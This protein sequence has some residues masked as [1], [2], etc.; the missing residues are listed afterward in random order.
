MQ[1][2]VYTGYGG[3]DPAIRFHSPG[4][5]EPSGR[6]AMSTHPFGGL[7]NYHSTSFPA[8]DDF[9][10]IDEERLRI[11]IITVIVDP[12]LRY[13]AMRNWYKPISATSIASRLLPTNEWRTHEFQLDSDG[14]SWTYGD[15]L[16]T[17]RR[18]QQEDRP[19]WLETRL[20]AEYSKNG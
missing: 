8:H 11:I 12:P 2:G 15:A 7:W 17:W 5:A 4:I 3:T 6:R 10:F 13:G 20:T 14:L 19:D 16:H 9:M 1:L 18:M